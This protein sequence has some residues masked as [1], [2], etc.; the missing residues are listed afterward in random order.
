MHGEWEDRSVPNVLTG[1]IVLFSDRLKIYKISFLNNFTYQK[2][3]IDF[4]ACAGVSH[5]IA[6]G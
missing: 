2:E 1:F 4:A 3:M 5:G 6:S